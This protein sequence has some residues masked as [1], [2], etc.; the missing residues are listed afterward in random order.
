MY[1]D[2]LFKD[3]A[4]HL[5]EFTAISKDIF[6]RGLAEIRLPIS[7]QLSGISTSGTV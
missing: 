6:I 4:P 5:E 1:R 2:S 3:N 7:R